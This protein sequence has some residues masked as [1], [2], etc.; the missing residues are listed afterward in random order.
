MKNL[1][2][3]YLKKD[4]ASMIK[5]ERIVMSYDIREKM[6]E[7]KNL[8]KMMT[9]KKKF[10]L[11]KKYQ[12]G[13]NKEKNIK[14]Q[15]KLN[16]GA[17]PLS[18]IKEEARDSPIRIPNL[19]SEEK[20]EAEPVSAPDFQRKEPDSSNKIDK[21]NYLC[22]DENIKQLNS[23]ETLKY[24]HSGVVFVTLSKPEGDIFFY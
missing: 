14:I 2:K 10:L 4:Y 18:E 6:K 12:K 20:N 8:N 5:V 1:T 23:P 11:K 13:K 22:L 17:E 21:L 7:I 3:I 16:N 24:K 9:Y 19:V 15:R